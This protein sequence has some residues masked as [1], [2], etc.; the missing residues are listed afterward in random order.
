MPVEV[1]VPQK[2]V[3]LAAAHTVVGQVDGVVILP[4]HLVKKIPVVVGAEVVAM[5]A[6]VLV[7]VLAL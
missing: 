2:V 7:V 5:V 6:M 4:D 1:V 3:L